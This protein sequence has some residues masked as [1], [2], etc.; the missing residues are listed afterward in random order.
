MNFP[1]E[2]SEKMQKV[3]SEIGLNPED[4]EENFTR[5]HGHGGQNINKSTNCVELTH[6]PTGIVVRYQHHRG[7]RQN[8]KE[9]WELLV[10]KVEEQMRGDQS[11]LR[12]LVFKIQKQKQRRSRRSKEQILE[13]KRRSSAIKKNRSGMRDDI[14]NT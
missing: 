11:A 5:G 2:I 10:L 1:V 3:A 9:A 7:L 4:V 14:E 6:K 8:R 12:Q 13:E